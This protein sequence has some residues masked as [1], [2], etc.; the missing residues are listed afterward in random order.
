MTETISGKIDAV[1]QSDKQKEFGY[2]AIKIGS[3]WIQGSVGKG[4][5]IPYKKGDQVTV[6]VEKDKD[7]RLKMVELDEDEA[8]QVAMKTP[9]K[10]QPTVPEQPKITYR[11]LTIKEKVDRRA[12]ALEHAIPH[13][14]KIFKALEDNG[15]RGNTDTI[16]SIL[17]ILTVRIEDRVQVPDNGKKK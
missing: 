1:A 3:Q 15:I 13:T 11:E 6:H 17:G 14:I 4:K 7:D 16:A 12:E 5:P 2:F 8:E 9:A 10:S